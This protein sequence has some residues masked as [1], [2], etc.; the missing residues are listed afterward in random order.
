MA[1]RPLENA[2]NIGPVS[3]AELDFIG[4]RTVAQ[5]RDYGWEEVCVR[6]AEAFPS[7]IHVNAF[8]AV[9]GAIEDVDW[10]RVDPELR[11]QAVALARRLKG[12]ARRV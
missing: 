4:I 6:W 9:I 8:L 5:M 11:R 2:R 7:R 10:R 1:V 3:A 12:G